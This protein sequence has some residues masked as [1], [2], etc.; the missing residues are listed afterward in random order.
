MP[1]QEW[2]NQ[3]PNSGL[4]RYRMRFNKE[5]IFV[6]NPKG[7]SEVLVQKSYEFAKPA[8]LRLG[9]GR[10][11]G[12]GLIVAEGNQHKVSK[13]HPRFK[14]TL[15][16]DEDS[17]I[18]GRENP[19]PLLETTQTSDACILAPAYQRSLS[20]LLG[21]VCRLGSGAT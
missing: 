20:H 13:L 19:P 6:T 14:T 7:L 9:L 16:D 11:L 2:V 12:V 15:R 21:Q 18:R 4:I 5:V 3:V 1:L 17:F 8:K 10:I